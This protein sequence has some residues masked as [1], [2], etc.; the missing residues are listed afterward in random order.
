[1]QDPVSHAQRNTCRAGRLRAVLLLLPL[2]LLALPGCQSGRISNDMDATQEN[3]LGKQY[4]QQI[5]S[6]AKFVT[7]G[8]YNRRI[9]A[10]AAPVFAQANKDRPDISFRVRVIDSPEV[11]AFSIPG[12]YV[13]VYRGLLDKLGDDDDAIAC[14]IGHESAHVVRRHVVKQISD[15][16]GKGIL[17]DLA[18][19]LS[20]SYQVGQIGNALYELDQ[21]HY[22]RSDEYEADRWGERFAYNAGYDPV[23][24][25]RTF[26][27]LED[28]E[29]R[30]SEP[31]PY[32]TDHP[33]NQN[34]SLR[35]LEQYRELRANGGQYIG[36][37]YNPEGD[38]L[39]AKKNDISYQALVLATTPLGPS[40]PLKQTGDDDAPPPPPAPTPPPSGTQRNPDGSPVQPGTSPGQSNSPILA[41]PTLDTRQ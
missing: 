17:V 6:Q 31:P 5:D 23:G 8:K 33:I 4:A 10:I 22:S 14:V 28:L 41:S 27:V 32:A 21:L 16:Q 26:H 12:G 30:S 2:A 1:M 29:K 38:K 39:A 7:D 18:T 35:A 3:D 15:A 9:L 34:R 25:V 19:L 20:R 37:V 36:E 24:M 11:N 40:T 13:Y